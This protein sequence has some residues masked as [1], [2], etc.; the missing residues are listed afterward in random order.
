MAA[1]RCKEWSFGGQTPW[2]EES[3]SRD[4]GGNSTGVNLKPIK[5]VVRRGGLPLRRVNLG[6]ASPKRE[7]IPVLRPCLSKGRGSKLSQGHGS[8]QSSRQSLKNSLPNLQMTK[9][10]FC[11]EKVGVQRSIFL[12]KEPFFKKDHFTKGGSREK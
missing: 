6:L 4:D 2:G 10:V 1:L 5:K 7:E 8:K 9:V 12:T 3:E 11:E